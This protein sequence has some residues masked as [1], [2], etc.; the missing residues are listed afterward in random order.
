[1]AGLNYLLKE[2]NF[3]NKIDLV[4]IDPPFATNGKFTVT[5]G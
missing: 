3:R 4:Y 2:R 1:M 5:D